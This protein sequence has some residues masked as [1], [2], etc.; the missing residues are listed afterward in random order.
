[1]HTVPQPT[2]P[3]PLYWIAVRPVDGSPWCVRELARL[4]K[5]LLRAPSFNFRCVDVRE[6]EP[7]PKKRAKA[8]PKGAEPED[9]PGQQRLFPGDSEA[10]PSK[11]R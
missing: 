7:P 2:P 9:V 8:R 1:M 10:R 11:A 4:L 5:I 3:S 6:E